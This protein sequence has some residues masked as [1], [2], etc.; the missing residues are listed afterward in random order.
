MY[1]PVKTKRH[2]KRISPTVFH[3]KKS[4]FV[5]KNHSDS[6]Q[7]FFETDIIKMFEFFIDSIFVMFG[8]RVFQHSRHSYGYQLFKSSLRKF[9]G[10]HHGLVNRIEMSVS[11]MTTDMFHLS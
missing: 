2:I 3:K 6:T 4:N 11:Q 9:Y 5:K 7:T 8:G 1:S 10:R